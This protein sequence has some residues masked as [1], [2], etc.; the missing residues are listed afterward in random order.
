MPVHSKP[1]PLLK[2]FV[3]VVGLGLIALVVHTVFGAGGYVDLQKRDAE[4]QRINEKVED[5]EKENRRLTGEVK[6]LKNDPA[7]IERVAREQLK[8]V[9][10][11]EKIITLPEK[12]PDKDNPSN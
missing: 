11:G 4:L 7:A 8:L 12:K 5:L 2:F 1:S 9:K 6:S 10:P 3:V